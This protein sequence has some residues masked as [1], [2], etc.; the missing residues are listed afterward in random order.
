MNA[1]YAESTPYLSGTVNAY[2]VSGRTVVEWLYLGYDDG[3]HGVRSGCNSNTSPNTRKTE[4]QDAGGTVYMMDEFDGS[5]KVP[6]TPWKLWGGRALRDS[7]GRSYWCSYEYRQNNEYV[8]RHR[9]GF[10]VNVFMIWMR[11]SCG[12]QLGELDR[13]DG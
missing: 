12:Q 8:T 11:E 6:P 9:L 3:S 4:K 13:I 5:S 10:Q 1:E 2:S 7:A